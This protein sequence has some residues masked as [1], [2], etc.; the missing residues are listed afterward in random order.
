MN[1]EPLQI[2]FRNMEPS[3]A[4]S[5]RIRSEVDKLDRFYDRITCCKVLVEAPHRH[6]R[7]GDQFHVRIEVAV[8]GQEIVIK[9]SPGKK[10]AFEAEGTGKWSKHLEEGGAHK[11]V[12]L[13]IRNSFQ[14]A[15]RRLEEYARKLRGDVK[16][17]GRVMPVRAEK[18]L[19]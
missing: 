12:Y 10:F 19:D 8:P 17:H 18:L 9:N 4:V 1:D 16:L 14:A 13:T 2:T 7:R 3:A 11:D 15:R 5:D 6:H